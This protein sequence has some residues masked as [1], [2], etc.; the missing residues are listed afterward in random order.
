MTKWIEYCKANGKIIIHDRETN[1]NIVRSVYLKEDDMNVIR[2]RFKNRLT[3]YKL[4]GTVSK[5]RKAKRYLVSIYKGK[6]ARVIAIDGKGDLK[7]TARLVFNSIGIGDR[8]E[9]D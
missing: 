1:K 8:V 2:E 7:N 5:K 6:K 9:V 3:R 4:I